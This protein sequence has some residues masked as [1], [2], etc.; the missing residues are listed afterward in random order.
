MTRV[1]RGFVA[2]VLWG[3]AL[4]AGA[5]GN[6]PAQPA[7]QPAAPEEAPKQRIK[8]SDPPHLTLLFTDQVVG[9]INPCG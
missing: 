2:I 8:P 6:P 9:Y 5:A 7:T 4:L 3:A 1:F